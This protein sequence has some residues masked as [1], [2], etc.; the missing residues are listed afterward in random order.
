[1]LTPGTCIRELLL[2]NKAPLNLKQHTF[3]ISVSLSKGFD[4]GLAC[5]CAA[6]S[7]PRLQSS[8]RPVLGCHLKLKMGKDPLP[9]SFIWS[10]VGFNSLRIIVLKSLIPHWL[11]AR[12]TLNSLPSGPLQHVSLL[13]QSQK[14][15]ESYSKTEVMIFCN[16]IMDGI[17]HQCTIFCWLGASYSRGQDYTRLWIPGVRAHGGLP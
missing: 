10:L 5:S 16:L 15:R 1:M 9:R 3:I 11:W 8:F 14:D 6:G 2:C 17:F 4:H 13:Y 12:V 7:L